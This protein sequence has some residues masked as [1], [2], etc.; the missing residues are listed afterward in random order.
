MS[1]MSVEHTVGRGTRVC[2][3]SVED[4]LKSA[5]AIRLTLTSVS[6]C[7]PREFLPSELL[8]KSSFHSTHPGGKTATMVEPP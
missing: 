6:S 7:A 4:V 8:N 3:D 2:F 1:R 5:G